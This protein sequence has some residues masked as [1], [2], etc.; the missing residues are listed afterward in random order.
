MNVIKEVVRI[1]S[2]ETQECLLFGYCFEALQKLFIYYYYYIS[3]LLICWRWLLQEAIPKFGIINPLLEDQTENTKFHRAVLFTERNRAKNVFKIYT[4]GSK[5]HSK[6]ILNKQLSTSQAQES[7]SL[8]VRTLRRNK[9][10]LFSTDCTSASSP[11]IQCLVL[12]MLPASPWH[13]GCK[14]FYLCEESRLE[15]AYN[16]MVSLC[17]YLLA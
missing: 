6:R 13:A 12:V 7:D 17:L 14:Y 8:Q 16:H 4:V 3:I 15:K 5:A 11:F 2:M 10:C 1:Q 9:C